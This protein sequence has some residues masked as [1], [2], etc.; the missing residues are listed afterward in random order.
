MSWILCGQTDCWRKHSGHFRDI[1]SKIANICFKSFNEEK[2]NQLLTNLM[3]TLPIHNYFRPFIG[4]L[5]THSIQ[6]FNNENAMKW[7]TFF[8]TLK[9]K[10]RGWRTQIIAHFFFL[11]QFFDW[12]SVKIIGKLEKWKRKFS[13][14][15]LPRKFSPQSVA[16][17][18][19]I[20]VRLIA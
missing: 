9:R 16:A 7:K 3:L 20:V 4:F 8:L 1:L 12:S 5:S 6:S 13:G 10:L 15:G 14:F 18:F 19:N 2:W 17:H 11:F